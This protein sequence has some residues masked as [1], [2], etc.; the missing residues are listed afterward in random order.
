MSKALMAAY[1]DYNWEEW[2]FHRVS[3]GY[4]SQYENV[5]RY[6]QELSKELELTSAADWEQV[7]TKQLSSLKISNIMRQHGGFAPLLQKQF[8]SHKWNTIVRT[9]PSKAQLFLFKTL[10]KLLPDVDIVSTNLY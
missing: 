4:W 3:K 10:R 5:N 2:K 6:F 7:S 9:S 8:T 1:P